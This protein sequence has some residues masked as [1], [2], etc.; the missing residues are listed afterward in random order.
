MDPASRAPAAK[1]FSRTDDSK[2]EEQRAGERCQA[3]ALY[4]VSGLKCHAGAP[5]DLSPQ[6]LV[7]GGSERGSARGDTST[8]HYA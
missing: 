4:L 5:S 1:L 7:S 8:S 6:R 3:R 2:Q